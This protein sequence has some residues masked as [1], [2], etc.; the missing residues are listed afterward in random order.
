MS[1][2]ILDDIRH[3][4]IDLDSISD[5]ATKVSVVFLLNSLEQLASENEKLKEQVQAQAD[6]INRLK[7]E[8][9]RPNIRRWI[10]LM[11]ESVT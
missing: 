1:A 7:G 8:Q 10:K 9:G 3:L 6:E 11:P 5:P 4:N 2:E